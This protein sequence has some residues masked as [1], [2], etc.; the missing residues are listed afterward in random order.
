[1]SVTET[2]AACGFE[3][4]A[5][6]PGRFSF[7]DTLIKVLDDWSNQPNFTAAMLHCEILNRLRHEKPEKR[8]R[9]K[10]FEYRRSPIHIVNTRDYRARSIILS[11]RDTRIRATT[12]LAPETLAY[13]LSSL[14]KVLATGE[15]VLPQVLITLAL[16]ED[17]ELDVEQCRR[18]LQEFPAL[19]KYA[20]VQGVYK[21]NSTLLL[22]SIPVVVWDFIPGDPACNFIGYVH[23]E[24]LIG[25]S[26]DLSV[27]SRSRARSLIS[28]ISLRFQ[29]LMGVPSKFIMTLVGL[30]C[31]VRLPSRLQIRRGFG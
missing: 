5:P 2:I 16:E 7:T 12:P 3:T 11:P 6:Q 13:D 18:W 17:Q 22:L 9:L 29:N 14:T 24:N 30:V 23:S 26:F 10:R 1:M 4:S 31:L 19:A 20:K 28:S 21:S 25:T 8:G 27:E 15:T